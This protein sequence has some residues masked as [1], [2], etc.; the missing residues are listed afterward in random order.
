MSDS[1]KRVISDAFCKFDKTG[2][3]VATIDDLR[4]SYNPNS[5]RKFQNGD[6]NEEQ[7]FKNFLDNFDSPDDKDGK[8]GV[9]I[10]SK[11]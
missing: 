4:G 6:W 3:G 9:S 5:H 11:F 2:D 10:S 7:T 1:R 8:V